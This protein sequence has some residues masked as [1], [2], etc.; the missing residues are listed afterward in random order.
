MYKKINH[1]VWAFDAEWVP[2]PA[3]GRLLYGLQEEP[4]DAKVMQEMWRRGG[5]TAEE[6]QPY[7]KTVLCRMVSIAAVIRREQ[8]GVVDLKLLS[9]PH[10]PAGA[11]A[12]TGPDGRAREREVVEPFLQ[13]LGKYKPTLVG[14]NSQAADLRILVQRGI[15]L[16]IQA[17]DFCHRPNKP[18]EGVDY[19]ARGSDWNIDLKEVVTPGWGPGTPSLH[20]IATQCGIPGKMDVSG[21]QVPNLWLGGQLPR[22][23]AYNEF[24]ALTTYLLWLRTLYFSGQH[25]AQQHEEEQERVR[26][27]LRREA[28]TA[29]K[30]HLLDYLAE[31]DRLTAAVA[32]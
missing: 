13:A 16:G 19:F 7:L 28:E 8:K 9:L 20:E 26:G 21:D 31:W 29:A 10:D 22:I 15:I 2:D 18:W 11:K 30:P 12:Q 17:R 4:D 24:D 32:R 25:S 3:A 6:P 27:L 5:A 1:P 23:V 14:Y